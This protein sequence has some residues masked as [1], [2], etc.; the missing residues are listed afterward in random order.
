M[1]RSALFFCIIATI[2][3]LLLLRDFEKNIFLKFLIR[4]SNIVIWLLNVFS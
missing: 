1:Q 3:L 4:L 2:L